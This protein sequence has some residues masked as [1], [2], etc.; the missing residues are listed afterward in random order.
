VEADRVEGIG[1]RLKPALQREHPY[2]HVPR[3]ERRSA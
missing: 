1:V 2:R 3:T